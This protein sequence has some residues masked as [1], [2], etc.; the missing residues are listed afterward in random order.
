MLGAL[1]FQPL[2]KT[3]RLINRDSLE[4]G[5]GGGEN[6][7][8]VINLQLLGDRRESEEGWRVATAPGRAC[9]AEITEDTRLIVRIKVGEELV[10]FLL[11]DGVVFV[12]VAT[13]TVHREPHPSG[14][15]GLDPIDDVFG[16]P[17]FDNATSL[18]VEAVITMEG[19]GH[20]LVPVRVRQQIAG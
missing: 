17:F 9:S 16:K 8:G 15:R 5:L 14:A 6:G 18:A 3:N 11:A 13:A 7:Q 1:T 12:V 10:E 19:R 4:G 2:G 20:D